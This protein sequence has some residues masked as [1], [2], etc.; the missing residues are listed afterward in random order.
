L[1]LSSTSTPLLAL[2][3]PPDLPGD[4][5]VVCLYRRFFASRRL[6]AIRE[7]K[8]IPSWGRPESTVWLPKRDDCVFPAS[9]PGG[10]PFPI[11]YCTGLWQ[12]DYLTTPPS[13]ACRSF[14]EFGSKSGSPVSAGPDTGRPCN[15]LNVTVANS[16]GNGHYGRLV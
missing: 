10:C 5:T 9:V 16:Q 12:G 13:A 15:A 14:S 2:Q 11:F 8:W 6:Q 4:R 7:V 3:T 1:V